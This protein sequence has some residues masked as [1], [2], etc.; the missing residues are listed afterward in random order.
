VSSTITRPDL[1]HHQADDHVKAGRLAGAVGAEQA[2][3][4]STRDVEADIANDLPAAI[5]FA[6]SL[7]AECLHSHPKVPVNGLVFLLWETA[8]R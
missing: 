6:D 3:N 5:G 1:R 8:F 2:H 4:F 7:G